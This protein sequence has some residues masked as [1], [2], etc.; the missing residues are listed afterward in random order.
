MEDYRSKDNQVEKE[1]AAFMDKH[2]YNQELFSR[3]SRVFN[4]QDQV[5]GADII[6]SIPSLN[7]K[8]AIVDEKAAVR[9]V[10]RHLS[11]YSLELSFVNRAGEVSNGWF[12]KPSN[13]TEYYLLQYIKADVKD[14]K[15]ITKDNIT[16]I[17][18]ILVSK[19]AIKDRLAQDHLN[20]NNL[21]YIADEVRAGR[22]EKFLHRVEDFPY[23]LRYSETLKEKPINLIMTKELYKELSVLN[24]I[25]KNK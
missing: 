4:K 25:I 14:W 12:I 1:I 19:Q 23:Y 18:V 20:D 11:T 17:E 15:E 7:I 10:N 6:I 24:L 3:A 13:K 9:Y 16:E 21:K 22:G 2:F 5:A 8:N